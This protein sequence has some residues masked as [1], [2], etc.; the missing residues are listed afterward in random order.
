MEPFLIAVLIPVVATLIVTFALWLVHHITGSS[1]PSFSLEA[2]TSAQKTL[3]VVRKIFHKADSDGGY[4]SHPWVVDG[5]SFTEDELRL[6]LFDTCA[7][8]GDRKLSSAIKAV[9]VQLRSAFAAS[10]MT[11]NTSPDFHRSNRKGYERVEEKLQSVA[12]SGIE[13]VELALARL[14]R[15]SKNL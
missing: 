3:G 7:R 2:V 5:K 15:L 12:L 9:S 10:D 1:K 14:R 4:L 13:S 8:I 6:A 11:M